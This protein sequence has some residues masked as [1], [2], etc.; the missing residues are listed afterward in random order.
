MKSK[1]IIVFPLFLF[2]LFASAQV[3]NKVLKPQI[4][5]M[6]YT[7]WDSYPKFSYAINSTN[8]NTVKI[9]GISWGVLAS[10]KHPLKNN[11][12]YLKSGLG[13]YRYSFNHIKAQNRFGE[14]DSRV[15][16][17]PSPLFII[18]HTNKY[19]YNTIIANIG[20]EKIIPIKNNYTLSGGFNLNNYFSFSQ[21]YRIKEDYPTGPPNNRYMRYE[22]KNVGGSIY[23]RLCLIK[24]VGR[25]NIGPTIIL[26]IL[27]LWVLDDAFPQDPFISEN[28]SQY[29]SKWLSAC[30][31]GLQVS[32]LL[33]SK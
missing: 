31:M 15:I 26:P 4:E 10:Y 11:K 2:C 19:W 5:I 23:F 32:Y 21:Y 24:Q 3:K 29:K 7:Q 28:P 6:P 9:H 18:F 22:K 27:N 12:L 16:N 1:L 17:F 14:T 25:L 13:Y 33:T 20:I 30:G 8:T